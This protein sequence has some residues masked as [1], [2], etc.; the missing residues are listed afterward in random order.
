[1]TSISKDLTLAPH[2]HPPSAY[3]SFFAAFFTASDGFSGEPFS[4]G[5]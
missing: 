5:L 3:S 1:M 2:L 4:F